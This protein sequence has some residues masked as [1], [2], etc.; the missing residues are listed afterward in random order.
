MRLFALIVLATA[1]LGAQ[2]RFAIAKS[3]NTPAGRIVDGMVL[4]L[5]SNA[6]RL[7]SGQ[8][9][10]VTIEVRSVSSGT[11]LV[12]FPWLSCAYELSFTNT[13]SNVAKRYRDKHCDANSSQTSEI[14]PGEST[15]VT[16][17]VP[18][19]EFAFQGT[20][21]YAVRVEEMYTDDA[22]KPFV[23]VTSNT[24]NVEVLQ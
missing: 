7:Q 3:A 2:D 21:A 8:A 12:A 4:S 5:T 14:P 10:Q 6:P 19:D 9:L 23:S 24:L 16:F 20:G 18:F 13:Q 22:D 1:L 17:D 15:F 11:L